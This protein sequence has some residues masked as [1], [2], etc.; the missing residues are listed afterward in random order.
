MNKL[1]VEVVNFARKEHRETIIQITDAYAQDPMGIGHPLPES[2]KEKMIA[3]LKKF[4]LTLIFI[5]FY[6]G[7][8][9]GLATC[10]FG[11]STFYAARLIN[12]HDLAVL[13][14]YRGKGIGSALLNAVEQKA[15]EEKCC[16]ITLEVRLDNRARTLYERNGFSL[17]EPGMYYMS[18]LLQ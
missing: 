1:E 8:A 16:K 11:F 14:K 2:S 10:F 18:K 15:K 7:E 9:A 3:E 6:K 17:G 13:K 4:P 12:I 5:A